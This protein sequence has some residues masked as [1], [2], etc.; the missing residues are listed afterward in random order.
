MDDKEMLIRVEQQLQDSLK[1]QSTLL[2]DLNE[3]FDKIDN[4]AKSN[5]T[6]QSE[7]NTH[8]ETDTVRKE[9]FERRI[10]NIQTNQKNFTDLLNKL[11]EE[12]YK[13]FASIKQE[14]SSNLKQEIKN[15]KDQI[16]AD[17]K[18][19]NDLKLQVKGLSATLSTM[20]SFL[21]WA[22]GFMVLVITA[23]WPIIIFFV[24]R[25]GP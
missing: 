11:E 3:I 13:E 22:S 25:K 20:S 15:L 21:K 7:L 4:E 8:L 23:I 19:A 10:T 18:E 9:D 12:I 17:K 16:D 1:N 6:I 24:T 5:A 2:S 14:I